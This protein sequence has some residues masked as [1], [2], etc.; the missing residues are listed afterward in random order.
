MTFA[1]PINQQSLTLNQPWSKSILLID[2][3]VRDSHSLIAAAQP[4]TEVHV[5]EKGD[6]IAQITDLLRDRSGIESLQIILQ[7]RAGGI[8][9]GQEWQSRSTLAESLDG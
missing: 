7:G 1:D 2:A 8:L 6:A 4:G 3:G 5:L 9:L